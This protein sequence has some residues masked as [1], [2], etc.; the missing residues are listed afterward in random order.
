MS[1]RRSEIARLNTVLPKLEESYLLKLR[2]CW[3]SL[4]TKMK[5]TGRYNYRKFEEYV[6]SIQI[7]LLTHEISPKHDETVEFSGEDQKR[8]AGIAQVS[9]KSNCPEYIKVLEESNR[10]FNFPPDKTILN[11]K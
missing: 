7:Q 5:E 6:T 4:V 8:T 10:K 3:T 11:P 1:L 9:N 2:D